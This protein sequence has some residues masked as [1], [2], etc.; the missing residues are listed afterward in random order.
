[1]RLDVRYAPQHVRYQHLEK[2]PLNICDNIEANRARAFVEVAVRQNLQSTKY[3]VQSTD[4]DLRTGSL[5]FPCL[6]ERSRLK[7]T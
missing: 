1:M 4:R 5:S 2:G 7:G 3:K 6:W